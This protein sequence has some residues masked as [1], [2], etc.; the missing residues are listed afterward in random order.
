[1][2]FKEGLIILIVICR[3]PTSEAAPIPQTSV[4]SNTLLT[5]LT[6]KGTDSPANFQIPATD[7]TEIESTPELT[8]FHETEY[9]EIFPAEVPDGIDI[10]GDT[11]V[12][13]K[14]Y[15]DNRPIRKNTDAFDVSPN[16]A[17][18]NVFRKAKDSYVLPTDE[19]LDEINKYIFSSMI[20]SSMTDQEKEEYERKLFIKYGD[21][22]DYNEQSEVDVKDSQ[23]YPASN[24]DAHIRLTPD[25]PEVHYDD[26]DEDT[27]VEVEVEE[28]DE[29]Y[30]APEE[31]TSSAETPAPE[32]SEE[33]PVAPNSA[34]DSGKE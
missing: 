14:Y 22:K 12:Q 27:K 19:Q 8:P 4:D 18:S 32:E 6:Y 11:L 1:M 28:I 3:I 17:T 31:T 23:P 9:E 30:V 21:K 20:L 15:E 7:A 34:E 25:C 13:Q 26:G 33:D 16:P 2:H 24:E 29:E 5:D 10:F